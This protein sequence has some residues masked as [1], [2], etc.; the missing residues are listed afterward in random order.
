MVPTEYVSLYKQ[1]DITGVDL[2]SEWRIPHYALVS[3]YNLDVIT[4]GEMD[5]KI[6]I[7][8]WTFAKNPPNHDPDIVY[9][10]VIS[11]LVFSPRVGMVALFDGAPFVF[12]A[13]DVVASG[14]IV[15]AV[16]YFDAIQ[17]GS[18]VR[19]IKLS[20]MDGVVKGIAFYQGHLY[21]A[22]QDSGFITKVCPDIM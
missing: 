11:Q 7:A 2:G 13:C 10:R 21:V 9:S 16:M 6:V 18:E 5:G 12:A 17:G 22:Q 15:P 3:G 1:L 8:L 4:Y 20:T 14:K 19:T